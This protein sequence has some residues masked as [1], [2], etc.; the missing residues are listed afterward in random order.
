V[1]SLLLSA[2][3]ALRAQWFGLAALCVALGAYFKIYPIALGMVLLV[4]YPR[5]FSWRFLLALAALAGLSFSLQRPA[6]VLSQYHLWFATRLADDRAN[7][8]I[9]RNIF[10]IFAALHLPVSRNLQL[11]LQAGSG[12]AIAVLAVLGRFRFRWSETRV[13]LAIFCLVD[14][15]M[16]LFGPATESATYVMLAPAVVLALAQSLG[17][18]L[19]RRMAWLA[20]AALAVLLSGTAINSFLRLGKTPLVMSV[21]PAGALLFA[22]FAVLWV[23]RDDF[24]PRRAAG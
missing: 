24:W 12:A 23:L 22:G 18:P 7:A 5:Q 8:G 17:Q 4:A 11:L 2:I 1:I 3:M 13:L 20:G 19:P 16:L 14:A 10:Q 6:Y 9:V 15:W 21:Q